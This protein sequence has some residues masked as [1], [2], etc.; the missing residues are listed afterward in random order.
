MVSNTDTQDRSLGELFGDLSREASHLVRHEVALAKAELS[1]KAASIGRD[2]GFISIG[3][4]LLYAG[5]LTLVAAAVIGLSQAGLDWWASAL[6]VGMV[7]TIAG[8]MSTHK[9]LSALKREQVRP[10]ETIDSM[11]ENAQWARGQMR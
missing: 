2:V 7:V 6:I 8:Y 3:G 4:A 9:G 11:K 5:L 1:E 10:T